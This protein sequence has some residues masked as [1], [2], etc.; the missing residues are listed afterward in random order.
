MK[1]ILIVTLISIV[2]PTKR[3][4]HMF[5]QNRYE[6]TRY[7]MWLQDQVKTSKKSIIIGLLVFIVS[8]FLGVFVN[9]FMSGLF[10][11][12]YSLTII[13]KELKSDYIK[14]LVYTARVIRQILIMVLLYLVIVAVAYFLGFTAMMYLMLLSPFIAY[15]LIYPMHVITYPIEATFRRL[16][17]NSAKSILKSNRDLIV[18]GITGSYGKTS[19]KNILNEILSEQFYTLATPASFNTP[20]GIT[21]TI[22]EQLKST[23]EAFIVEMGADKVGDIVEL[24]EFVEPKYALI[25][26]IGPQHLSTFKKLD[27]IIKEKMSLAE[28]LPS[29]GV[30][31]LN[32]DNVY[33]NDYVMNNKDVKTVSYGIMNPNVDYQAVDI[34]YSINGSHFTVKHHNEMYEFNTRL[35]GEHNVLNILSGIAL[36]RELG[37]TWE[38]LQIAVSNVKFI[39]HRLE[40]KTI[41]NRSFIDNAFNSNPEGANMSLKV[42]SMMPKTRYIVTPGMIDLGPIQDDENYKFGYNMKDRVDVAILVGKNQTKPI[43]KGL[44]DSGFIEEN[45]IVFDTV[46]EALA[47]VYQVSTIDDIILLENDLPDAFNN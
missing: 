5:Q 23:H 2:M 12:F 37:I 40:L 19:S 43:Y 42:L 14:P 29:D 28:K 1:W 15:I 27:N 10:I 46:K 25:T 26:S 31:I 7:T 41:N 36:G 11:L 39:E 6:A 17:K 34:K 4:L 20:M 38:K 32:K 8:F 9:S 21:I 13:E 30:A 33:I 47:Y 18:V 16:F 44:L 3:A 22:R 35:L 24:S 45:I